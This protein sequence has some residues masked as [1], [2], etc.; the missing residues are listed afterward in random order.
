M[1]SDMTKKS[2]TVAHASSIKG[3]GGMSFKDIL[4][5]APAAVAAVT[6]LGFTALVSR[7]WAYYYG[8]G[9]VD[10]ISLTSPANYIS[11]ALRE[12]PVPLVGF[13]VGVIFMK[14]FLGRAFGLIL[15][16]PSGGGG[17]S[18]RVLR[19]GYV[20]FTLMAVAGFGVGVVQ[21]LYVRTGF[22]PT[23]G[24]ILPRRG[25]L[26]PVHAVVCYTPARTF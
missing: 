15:G 12:L 26:G 17:L 5:G 14:M 6:A 20:V 25:V 13:V 22:N 4:S 24:W 19:L 9:A 18:Q 11:A 7:E 1:D 10:F 8:L 3:A 23:T 16:E 21:F 2:K